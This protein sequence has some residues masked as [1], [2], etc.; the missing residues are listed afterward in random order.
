[1]TCILCDRRPAREGA[2]CTNCA[3]KVSV[4]RNHN[5]RQKPFRFLTYRGIVVGMYPNGN[6]TL[7]PRLLRR[8]P[9]Y[10]PKRITLDLNTY[11][12]GFTRA[13]IK[14]MKGVCLQLA[15]A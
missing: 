9:K 15:N 6:G 12:E 11:L 10:L 5:T 3:A 7:K 4:E 2:F 1:M 13:Q 8:D 14:K